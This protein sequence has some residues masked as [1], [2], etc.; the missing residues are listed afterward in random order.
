[1]GSLHYQ[2]THGCLSILEDTSTHSSLRQPPHLH[3]CGDAGQITGQAP[4]GNVCCPLPGDCR[5]CLVPI[6]GEPVNDGPSCTVY[7]LGHFQETQFTCRR[8]MTP[9]CLG[10]LTVDGKE[11]ALLRSSPLYSFSYQLLYHW[12]DLMARGGVTWF[13]FWTD[14]VE[15]CA[16]LTYLSCSGDLLLHLSCMG[17]LLA[18]PCVLCMMYA[19]RSNHCSLTSVP[20]ICLVH[21]LKAGGIVTMATS[22]AR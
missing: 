19:V 13:R 12:A 2:Q 18:L 14:T 15:R 1:M 7:Y 5:S 9:G 8:C 4:L 22:L 21:A 3:F 11:F 6:S 20:A 10:K 17:H 16:S